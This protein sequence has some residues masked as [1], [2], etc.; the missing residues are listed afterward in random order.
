[1][2]F[3][4]LPFEGVFEIVLAPS[5]DERGYFCR[6]HDVQIFRER[7]LVADW[8]QENE[9]WSKHPFTIRGLHFQRPPFAETKLIRVVRGAVWDVFVDLRK[10]STTFGKWG[11]AE[12]S[13][14]NGKMLYLPKGFAHGYCTL[15][16][17]VKMLYRVDALH[18]PEQEG[19]LRWDDRDLGI[20]WPKGE[21][22]ISAKDRS[23]PNWAGFISTFD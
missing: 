14:E 10:S 18:A 4:A 7:G 21:P 19:G 5:V 2:Q 23:W 13:S 17:D 12:L 22:I 11:A 15:T 9:A 20:Q 6:T 8:V 16:A 1:M 3:H